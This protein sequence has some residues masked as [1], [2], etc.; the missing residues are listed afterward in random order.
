MDR[1]NDNASPNV[2]TD[3]SQPQMPNDSPTPGSDSATANQPEAAISTPSTLTTD[4]SSITEPSADDL[5]ALI[6]IIIR[7]GLDQPIPDLPVKIEL[8]DGPPIETT[9][10]EHGAVTMPAGE[11]KGPAT[12]HVRDMTGQYQE[13]CKVDPAKCTAGTAIVRSPKVAAKVPLRPHHAKR[14]ASSSTAAASPAPAQTPSPTPSTARTQSAPEN[15]QAGWLEIARQWLKDVMHPH[16]AMPAA[17]PVGTQRQVTAQA[18][19]TSGNPITIVTGPDCPNKDNLRL[20]RNDIYRQIILDASKKFNMCPQAL[21]A[22]IDAEA[23]KI[24]DT[25][26]LTN[27]DGT[28]KLI[29][30]GKHKGKPATRKIG[31]HWDAKSVNP[32]GAA[33][34]T[35]FIVDTW[36]RHT[37]KRGCYINEQCVAKG[38]V[39]EI[40]DK[41]GGVK[42]VFVLADGRTTEEPWHH[43]SDA[44][45]RVCLDQ[46]FVAEWS[47]MA[48]AD[49]GVANLERLKKLGFKL[50]G[51]NDVEKAKLMYLMHHEGEP[52]GPLV[53]KNKLN[54]LPKGKYASVEA[55]IRATLIKQVGEAKAVD[56]IKKANGDVAKAY[57][58][59]LAGYINDKIDFKNFCCDPNKFPVPLDTLEVFE[60]IGGEK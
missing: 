36:L 7:D 4:G 51:L 35:Q 18:A 58:N 11:S 32:T 57:R 31:D 43:Q 28:P 14:P 27:P 21:A 40:K 49:Y 8:P 45:V 12:V 48:A 56:L 50:A 17:P 54:E 16:D 30:S 15:G 19:N 41:R 53:I 34:L 26:A 10:N 2:E 37:T 52:A 60:K 46:R 25:I 23:G 20:G 55:R 33:G 3:V 47:I 6:A 5:D 38:W 29:K 9:T 22:L 13:V 24:D 1:N 44:N 39:K 59:W 42:C